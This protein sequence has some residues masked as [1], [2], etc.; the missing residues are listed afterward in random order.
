MVI[1]CDYLLVILLGA[2]KMRIFFIDTETTGLN[3]PHA[4]SVATVEVSAVKEQI[5]WQFKVIHQSEK[6]FNPKKAITPQATAIHGKSDDDV[7]DFT[8]IYELDLAT[9]WQINE[10]EC[11]CLIGHNIEFDVNTLLNTANPSN[12]KILENAKKVCSLSLAKNVLDEQMS[13][14]LGTLAKNVLGKQDDELSQLHGALQDSLLDVNLMNDLLQKRDFQAQSPDELVADL[15]RATRRMSIKQYGSLNALSK[16]NPLKV[17]NLMADWGQMG[18]QGSVLRGVEILDGQ[19]KATQEVLLK[20]G[21]FR[22]IVLM[23]C[24]EFEKKLADDDLPTIKSGLPSKSIP[25][26]RFYA[27]DEKDYLNKYHACNERLIGVDDNNQLWVICDEK[28]N[29]AHQIHLEQ[30]KAIC[31]YRK[32]VF[33]YFNGLTDEVAV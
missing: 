14:R 20:R 17:H 10:N 25:T 2:S 27:I 19:V 8:P 33:D 11:V 15:M 32:Y 13:Y 21:D 7:A 22:Q 23:G 31:E 3:K 26:Y 16:A 28:D 6:H 12:K 18:V 5:G 4:W 29:I 9:W 1:F 30:K 24:Q